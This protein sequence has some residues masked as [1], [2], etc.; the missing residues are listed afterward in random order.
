V[1]RD[2]LGQ[3]AV[4]LVEAATKQRP[5]QI[6]EVGGVGTGLKHHKIGLASNQQRTVRLD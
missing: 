4:Q 3:I 5:A 1:R 6:Q 2:P